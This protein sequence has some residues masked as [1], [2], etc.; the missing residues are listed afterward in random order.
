[1]TKITLKPGDYVRTEGMT[2]EQYHAVAKAFLEA[3]CDQGEYSDWEECCRLDAFGWANGTHGSPDSLYHGSYAEGRWGSRELTIDQILGTD[4]DA[5][6]W[7]EWHGGEC[8]VEKGTLVDVR[9][10]GGDVQK[11]IPALKPHDKGGRVAVYWGH[12]GHGDGNIIAYR[13]H[14][15]EQEDAPMTI[16][17]LLAKA[18]KHAAKAA[19]HE[20]KRQALIEQA[21]ELMPE[22]W[23]LEDSGL[24]VQPTE[25]MTDPG[26]WKAG[27]V[28]EC[29]QD[30]I[31]LTAGV[32]YKLRLTESGIAYGE[33][34]DVRIIDDD[35]DEIH[36][37]ARNFKW[38]SRPQ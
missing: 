38:I 2:E 3:G 23:R 26:N 37:D 14:Q 5:D 7:I 9:Y 17:Q 30:R 22:G 27:D 20:A 33:D 13:L 12:E 36:Y 19:K 21:R 35:G 25:D 31:S 16:E 1:M 29:V 6:G 24:I 28:V 34:G 8:P 32:Q 4:S 10:R 15:P 11:A 18:N